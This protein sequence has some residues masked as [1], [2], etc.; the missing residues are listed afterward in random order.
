MSTEN[1]SSDDEI[2]IQKEERGYVI[3]TFI[4]GNTK[5][6]VYSVNRT[7]VQAQGEPTFA[8]DSCSRNVLLKK[9]MAVRVL[10]SR[11]KTNEAHFY[12]Y[13]EGEAKRG[14]DEVCSLLWMM[15]QKMD[16]KIKELHVLAM[17]AVGK[18]GTTL[19]SVQQSKQYLLPRQK[20]D[21]LSVQEERIVKRRFS[22]AYAVNPSAHQDKEQERGKFLKKLA[23]SLVVPHI[24]KQ[25]I[26]P[27][28]P[29][30]LVM[31]LKR[32]LGPDIPSQEPPSEGNIVPKHQD[33][34]RLI[35]A[36]PRPRLTMQDLSKNKTKPARLLRLAT[37]TERRFTD[38]RRLVVGI[39]KGF[40]LTS[41]RNF[42]AFQKYMV[43]IHAPAASIEITYK[44]GLLD[45]DSCQTLEELAT[46][47]AVD[48]STVG[49]HLK[50]MEMIQKQG[51]WVPYR[52]RGLL[53]AIQKQG[54]WV[55]YGFC[56][57]NDKNERV[58][59]T[60]LSLVMKNG[61]IMTIPSAESHG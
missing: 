42:A 43:K 55:S 22:V 52:S 20:K 23:R 16:P 34:D 53:G 1:E 28:L 12:T 39:I 7:Q 57:L 51:Y 47:L 13:H 11:F 25:V 10:R 26:N 41:Q 14:P 27:H 15:I 56:C 33:R 45:V 35:L 5:H 18:I 37:R 8:K 32:V 58:F 59:Y 17:L 4:K 24:Q 30:E 60:E 48:L 2:N 36:R 40:V 46:S 6:S 9:T 61:S 38:A 3:L 19:I 31:T 50:T 29:N 54:Y 49:K 44:H 21:V